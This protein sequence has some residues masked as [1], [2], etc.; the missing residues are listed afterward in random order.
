MSGRPPVFTPG[1]IF[2]VVEPISVRVAS[3]A[4][5]EW[6]W[7]R[8]VGARIEESPLRVVVEPASQL[9][10]VLETIDRGLRQRTLSDAW[11]EPAQ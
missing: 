11:V 4:D 9:E 6:L 2:S 10:R 7:S 1:G 8:F 5:A 3:R